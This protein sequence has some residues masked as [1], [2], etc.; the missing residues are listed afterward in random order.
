MEHRVLCVEV[1]HCQLVALGTG[2]EDAGAHRRWTVA[3]VRRAITEGQ[4]FFLLSST[5]GSRL[6]LECFADELRP[7]GGILPHELLGLRSCRWR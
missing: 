7:V 4:R 5:L 1:E 3:E 6:Y 2:D